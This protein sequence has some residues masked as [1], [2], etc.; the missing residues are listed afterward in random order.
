MF[1]NWP[2]P[3]NL[4]FLCVCLG[5]MLFFTN[6]TKKQKTKQNKTKQKTELSGLESFWFNLFVAQYQYVTTFLFDSWSLD[7]IWNLISFKTSVLNSSFE[8]IPISYRYILSNHYDDGNEWYFHEKVP[9]H[10]FQFFPQNKR[11]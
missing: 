4:N 11:K 1:S 2:S 3:A 6:I 8:H 9:Q 10:I 7:P 5:I